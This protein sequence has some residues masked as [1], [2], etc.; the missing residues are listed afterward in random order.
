LAKPP[1]DVQTSYGSMSICSMLRWT[2]RVLRHF[3]CAWSITQPSEISAVGDPISSDL[4]E[5]YVTRPQQ[6]S[7]YVLTLRLLSDFSWCG[8]L[9][10]L[11]APL[12][13]FA[14]K[15]IKS[16]IRCASPSTVCY[17]AMA[18]MVLG[19]GFPIHGCQLSALRLLESLLRQFSLPAR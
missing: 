14:T 18:G 7:V 2:L 15:R 3:Y 16:R 17:S 1:S 9:I 5:R 8:L 11:R 12:I 13:T 6:N 19:I 4:N 10:H